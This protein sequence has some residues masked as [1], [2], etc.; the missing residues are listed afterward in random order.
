M[1]NGTGLGIVDSLKEVC[2]LEEEISEARRY[3]A[4]LAAQAAHVRTG[5]SF[6]RAALQLVADGHDPALVEQMRRS[7]IEAYYDDH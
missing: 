5:M 7:V 3:N 2:A 1:S 6:T 4:V